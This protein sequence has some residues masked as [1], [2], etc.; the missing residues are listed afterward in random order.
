MV[1][2]FRVAVDPVDSR[3][4]AIEVVVLLLSVSHSAPAPALAAEPRMSASASHGGG[5]QVA[6]AASVTDSE[7]F[8]PFA[9]TTL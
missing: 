4:L 7:A 6:K 9:A 3:R 8:N 2:L 1:L 5:N